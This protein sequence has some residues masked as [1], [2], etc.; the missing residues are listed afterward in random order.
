MA[1]TL[2]CPVCM[3]LPEDEVHQCNEGH[4]YCVECWNRLDPRVFC[5]DSVEC[6]SHFCYIYIST[7]GILYS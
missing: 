1:D 4:C 2:M 3:T 6:C 5:V 7:A